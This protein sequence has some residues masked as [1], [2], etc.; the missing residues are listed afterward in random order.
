MNT[1]TAIFT[2]PGGHRHPA[3][4]LALGTLIAG[5]FDLIFAYSFWALQAD[6]PA[7]RILQSIA[8]GLIGK[9]SFQGGIATATLGAVL[10]Y[11][12]MLAMVATY[13]FASRRLPQLVQ[14]PLLYG[15][16]Y[17]AGLYVVMHYIVVPLSAARHGGAAL[18]LWTAL[19]IVAHVLIGMICAWFS[20]RAALR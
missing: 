16:I 1:G 9:A 17:G 4:S 15:A 5:T 8:S 14:R 7:Q 12:I 6:V 20:R 3:T 10:H 13:Y 2:T 11:I 19:S 18:P